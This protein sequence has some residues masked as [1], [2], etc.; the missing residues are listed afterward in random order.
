MNRE[1]P[2]GLMVAIKRKLSLSTF[3]AFGDTDSRI[4]DRESS[5]A[6]VVCS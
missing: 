6:E 5:L 2:Q 3:E 4:L 1:G